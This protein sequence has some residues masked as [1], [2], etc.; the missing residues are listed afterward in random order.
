MK[1][2]I[3]VLVVFAALT[4]AV[5]AQELKF[6]AYLD[7][8][9]GVVS[10][11]IKDSDTV[12]KAYAVDAWQNGY[13]FRLNGSWTGEEKNAGIRFRLQSQSK[14]AAGYIS[15]SYLYG[16]VSFLDNIFTVSGGIVDDSAWQTA[17]FWINADAGEGL[18]ALLKAKPVEGLDLGFGAYIASQLG[19]GD[20][21]SLASTVL[22]DLA[23]A[24]TTIGD[25]KYVYSAA[26]TLPE[27][28]RIGAS[29]RWKNKAGH[30]AAATAAPYS[31]RDESSALFGDLRILAVKD[32]TAV[33]AFSFDKIEDFDNSGNITFSE[34][35][36]Y[37]IEDLGL[38]LNAAQ[39]FYKRTAAGEK[40]DY[41]PGLFFNL[42]ASYA[43]GKVAP[44]LDLVYFLGG[45]SNPAGDYTKAKYDRHDG[46][47]AKA[48]TADSDK[49]D[50][51]VF[52][53]RP[54]V[55]FNI[56]GNAS[57]EIGDMLNFD[58]ATKDGTYKK[59]P[60]D[61][62]DEGLNRITNVFYIDFK[63]SF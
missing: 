62:N 5:F 31:G 48:S 41:D 30:N 49:D 53:L 63:W 1:K 17:D 2:V 25:V 12:V 56:N 16:W 26:Y 36:A 37:K 45:A 38:G 4:A 24:V 46:F 50:Y 42:W 27:V 9:L 34:T 3:S 11:D 40:V 10:S 21:N 28:F 14:L 59:D 52:S 7:T 23:N 29:F 13:R 35:F 55:K 43:I 6:G 18:G 47:A 58:A 19:G 20:N 51:S 15:L 57:I 32:L 60:A 39:F 61:A 33:V 22:L 44:R 8:G 54:S